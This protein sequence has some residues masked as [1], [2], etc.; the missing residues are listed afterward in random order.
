MAHGTDARSIANKARPSLGERL[1]T[2][3]GLTAPDNATR[4]HR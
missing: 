3:R 1:A 2:S 4:F